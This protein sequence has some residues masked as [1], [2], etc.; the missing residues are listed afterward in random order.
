MK[1]F[2][3]A[4]GNGTRLR[5]LTDTVPKC[6]VP[7]HGVPLLGIW[8]NWCR[9]FGIDEV[10]V[11]THAHAEAVD[12][13]LKKNVHGV[14]TLISYEP[15][16]LG[17]AGTLRQ[18]RSFVA[19]ELSFAVL[20][21]DVLTNADFGKMIRFHHERRSS[22]TIG[23]YRVADPRQCG[24]VTVSGD[25]VVTHFVEKPAQPESDLAFTGLMLAS[26]AVLDVIPAKLPVDIG[27]DLLPK[28]VGRMH[29]FTVTDYLVDIGDMNKYKRAQAEWPGWP[30]AAGVS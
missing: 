3:L 17:S 10:L 14:H 29:A 6:L 26:P 11:N 5:P 30:V 7:I 25:G 9:H 12:A 4:A 13:Y 20:Y 21:A 19:G 15:E 16:L 28:L 1:A 18:N 8:L 22:A 23:V 27:S 2:L 24:I